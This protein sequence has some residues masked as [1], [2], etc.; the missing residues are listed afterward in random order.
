MHTPALGGESRRAKDAPP[1]F[2]FHR[3]HV[4]SPGLERQP[5]FSERGMLQWETLIELK[6]LNSSFSSLS[7]H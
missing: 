5:A 4:S 7:S 3:A 1:L 6:F 2:H